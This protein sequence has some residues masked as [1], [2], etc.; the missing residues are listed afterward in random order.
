MD[1]KF[2]EMVPGTKGQVHVTVE[3]GGHFSQEEEGVELARVLNDFM[4]RN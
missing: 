3:G 4:A 2:L 1:R